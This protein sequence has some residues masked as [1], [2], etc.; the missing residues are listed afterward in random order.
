LQNLTA[1][2]VHQAGFLSH[3]YHQMHV[4]YQEELLS[5]YLAA[6]PIHQRVVQRM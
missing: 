6:L 3:K 4:G 1:I 5:E 2:V